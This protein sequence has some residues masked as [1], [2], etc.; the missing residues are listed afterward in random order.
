MR[1]CIPTKMHGVWAEMARKYAVT[2]AELE[3]ADASGT[4]DSEG[5][6]DAYNDA[7]DAIL[8]TP[9]QCAAD[10]RLKIEVMD[11]HDVSD[12][13]W[14][15]AEAIAILAIDARDILPVVREQSK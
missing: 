7:V 13:W 4:D 14:C 8:L 1:R 6:N 2:R 11:R 12:G 3:L 10:I 15:L 5:K 9:A